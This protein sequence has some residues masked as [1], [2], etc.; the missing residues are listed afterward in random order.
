MLWSSVPETVYSQNKHHT[1]APVLTVFQSETI[2]AWLSDMQAGWVGS[3]TATHPKLS[4]RKFQAWL[5]AC[6]YP[7][8]GC[9]WPAMQAR[10]WSGSAPPFRM[11]AR[12]PSV[13]C[14]FKELGSTLMRGIS[15]SQH[16]VRKYYL[17]WKKPLYWIDVLCAF[18]FS[19]VKW[20]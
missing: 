17:G 6:L 1:P 11:K 13:S 14:I 9:R 2:S 5:Q 4:Y 12:I 16:F 10:S 3:G 8:Q 7:S 19:S 20:G 18:V 15:A